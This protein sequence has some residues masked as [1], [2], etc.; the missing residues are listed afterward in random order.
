MLD[1]DVLAT[2]P[3]SHR[4]WQDF[5][6][7]ATVLPASAEHWLLTEGSHLSQCRQPA[8]QQ[9]ALAFLLRQI[10]RRR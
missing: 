9:L 1:G 7:R 5:P 4:Q 6:L 3:I 10:L 8:Q 2:T